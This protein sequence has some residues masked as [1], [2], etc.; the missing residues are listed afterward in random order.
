MQR[1]V[2]PFEQSLKQALL[3][4]RL[5]GEEFFM[6]INITTGDDRWVLK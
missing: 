1:N 2:S 4:S 3:N 5:P 6:G